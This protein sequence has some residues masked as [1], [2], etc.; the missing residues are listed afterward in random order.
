MAGI[1]PCAGFKYNGKAVFYG[2]KTNHV[3]DFKQ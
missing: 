2:F 3:Y 1:N